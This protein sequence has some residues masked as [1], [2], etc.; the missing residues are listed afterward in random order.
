VAAT[1]AAATGEL[2]YFL[3]KRV[4]AGSGQGAHQRQLAA[5]ERPRADVAGHAHCNSVCHALY[6]DTEPGRRDNLCWRLACIRC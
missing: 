5:A 2:L 4:L 3:L 1:A 6:T